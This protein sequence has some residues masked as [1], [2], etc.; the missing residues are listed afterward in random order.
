[1]KE[2]IAQIL[3]EPDVSAKIYKLKSGRNKPMPDIPKLKEQ[4]NVMQHRT[5]VDKFYLPDRI[6]K[7][8]EN[9]VI[10][11]VNRIALPFQKKIVNTAVS[12]AFGNPVVL[13][14]EAKG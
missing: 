12:F 1:M 5:M 2:I 6:V 4:W 13:N 10:Q 8:G 9:T 3:A 7:K 14:C 11:P